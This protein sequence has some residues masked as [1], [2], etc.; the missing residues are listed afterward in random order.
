VIFSEYRDGTPAALSKGMNAS[1]LILTDEQMSTSLTQRQTFALRGVKNLE[2]FRRV[3][4]ELARLGEVRFVL[5]PTSDVRLRDYLVAGALGA[6]DAAA[7]G[8][9]IGIAVGLLAEEPELAGLGAMVGALI[10][11]I[12]GLSRVQS[13]WRV[14]ARWSLDQAPELLLRPL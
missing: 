10:G 11:G 4:H 3:L 7:L 1:T 14:Q 12:T 9:V 2:T 6:A 8:A 13:G 5:E